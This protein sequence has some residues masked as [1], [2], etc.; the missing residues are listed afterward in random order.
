[1]PARLFSASVLQLHPKQIIQY[2]TIRAEEF[3]G[4]LQELWETSTNKSIK[5][6]EEIQQDW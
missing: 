3:I 1:M 5:L 4:D 6:E 2:N